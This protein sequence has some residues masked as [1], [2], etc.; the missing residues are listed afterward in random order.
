LVHAAERADAAAVEE[1]AA[2][3]EARVKSFAKSVS[4]KYINPPT[5]TDY[6]ILFLPTEPLLS[7]VLRRPGL[8]DQLQ[9]DC[10][11]TLAGPQRFQQY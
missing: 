9:R 11:V 6:A 8:F 10:R 7:E 5:T 4:E 3:L 2:A 1:A